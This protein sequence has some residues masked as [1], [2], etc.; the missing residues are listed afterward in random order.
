VRDVARRVIDRKKLHC[1]VVGP[2]IDESE[3][4]AAMA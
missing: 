4:A 3:I 2:D 1:A